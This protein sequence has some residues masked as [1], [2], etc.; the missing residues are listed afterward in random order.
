[1]A[2]ISVSADIEEVKQ[3][4]V[5]LGCIPFDEADHTV[6]LKAS[7]VYLDGVP[8]GFTYNPGELAR[9][10]RMLRR[11]GRL[12]SEVNVAYFGDV[13]ELYVNCD[14]GRC[15]RP[16]IIVDGG[17]PLLGRDHMDA[18]KE[19]AITWD[20]LVRMGI[21]EYIDAEEE[22]NCLVALNYEDICMETTHIE[23]APY[24]IFGVCASLIPYAEH[25]HSPRNSYEAAMAKQALGVYA[26]NYYF[27][28]DSRGHLLHYPQ[29]PIV[30]TKPMEVMGYHQRPTGQNLVV[31]IISYS[32]YNMEDAVIFNKSS[33]DR[34]LMRSTF[35]KTY[36]AECYQY[37]GGE[38]DRFEIPSSETKGYKGESYYEKL[39]SDG[40]TYPECELSTGDALVGKTSPPR[41][42]EEYRELGAYGISRRDTSLSLKS[43]GPAIVD[44]VV[45][46]VDA[47]G[48]K[49]A[50]V[51]V[52][53]QRI[54]ELGD[55]FASRHGQKGVIGIVFRQEDMP[56]TEDGLI[57]DIIINP[58]AIPSRMTVGQLM[59]S[60]AGKI[61]AITGR[62]MDGTAF[63][64]DSADKL[65]EILRKFGFRYGGREIMYDGTTGYKFEA[66]IFIGIVYYQKLHHMVSD[67]IHARARGQVQMLTRQP[68]EGRARGGGLR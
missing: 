28:V 67:K 30:Q 44:T 43:K 6:R 56:F 50:K 32:G 65:D 39:E 10:L 38:T 53:E 23:I 63:I 36:E 66:D 1:M 14:P 20:E 55:K 25:N 48:N 68:T 15:R 59:E 2:N 34:G 26:T 33:I 31:A 60:I 61:G 45:L 7:R 17:R 42:M 58:H 64:N 57:P 52:R 54:P 49:V 29:I 16:L 3:V 11:V 62:F 27:R 40:L 8:F 21:I 5:R 37:M 47:Q 24:T 35:F 4:L 9:E 19:G 22:E 41:F 12:S 18:L 13:N 51:K 46:T